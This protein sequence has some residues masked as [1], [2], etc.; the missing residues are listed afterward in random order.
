MLSGMGECGARIESVLSIASALDGASASEPGGCAS[1]G[2]SPEPVGD[3]SPPE[4]RDATDE[5]EQPGLDICVV[6]DLDP[7]AVVPALA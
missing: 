7:W 2:A 3:A 5:G 6:G 1:G 4:L